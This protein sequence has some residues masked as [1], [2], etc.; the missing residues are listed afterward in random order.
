MNRSPQSDKTKQDMST[1]ITSYHDVAFDHARRKDSVMAL[2][3]MKAPRDT[4]VS[5][6]REWACH[7]SSIG[8]ARV[9]AS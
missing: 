1:L 7:T 3:F 5:P 9:S 2:S 4:L 8:T 6:T